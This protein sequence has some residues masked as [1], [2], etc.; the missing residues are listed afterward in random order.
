MVGKTA[1]IAFIGGGHMAESFI[2]GLIEAGWPASN[3]SVADPDVRRREA[4]GRFPGLRVESRNGTAVAGA[5][6]VV[7]AVK[8]PAVS[9]AI[10]A[11]A[12]ELRRQHSVVLSIAAGVRI[13]AVESAVGT[14]L[15][16]V[17]AMPNVAALIGRGASAFYANRRVDPAGLQLARETLQAVGETVEVDDESQLD[18]VTAVSG[19]GPAYFFLLVEAL[20]E[21]A[22]ARGLP[23]VAA[24]R[25]VT[26]TGAGALEL[27]RRS[28]EE[29]ST[30][31]RQVT[32]PGGTTAAAM[33]IL[34][35]GDFNQLVARAVTRAAERAHELGH[36]SDTAGH[37]Q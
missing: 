14:E 33:Q 10:A 27:L 37:D 15:A 21:A 20:E 22:I 13:A 18:A 25:L 16:V 17:R 28:G 11:A 23:A 30:L 24:R 1:R 26:A 7:V 3:L 36:E 32:S 29:P 6:L 5:D 31:R 34:A 8:P 4:L 12:P 19:S 35:D 2:G 9:A